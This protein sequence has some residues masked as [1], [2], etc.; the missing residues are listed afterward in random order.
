MTDKIDTPRTNT[1]MRDQLEAWSDDTCLIGPEAPKNDGHI[2]HLICYLMTVY[3][4]FG[5]TAV[6]AQLQWGAATSRQIILLN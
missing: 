5:N 1:R 3:E 6:T 2:K 4:R